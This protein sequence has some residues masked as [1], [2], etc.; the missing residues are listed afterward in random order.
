[1]ALGIYELAEAMG[2]GDKVGHSKNGKFYLGVE[3]GQMVQK[4]QINVAKPVRS[5]GHS[6]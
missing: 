2:K 3:N 6:G 1:M 4:E 5:W